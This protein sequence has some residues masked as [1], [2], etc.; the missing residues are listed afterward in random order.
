M[1][2]GSDSYQR[3]VGGADIVE[4][5]RPVPDQASAEREGHFG[6]VGRLACERVPHAAVGEFAHAV[7]VQRPYRARILELDQAAERVTGE[8]AEQTA[9]RSAPYFLGNGCRPAC[10]RVALCVPVEGVQRGSDVL[11][12]FQ[13]VGSGN[14]HESFGQSVQRLAHRPGNCG[15]GVGVASERHRV[16]RRVLEACRFERADERCR[17]RALARHIEAM[18]WADRLQT[19]PQVVA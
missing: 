8:L 11:G 15:Q 6:V 13:V 7:G 9:L 18:G 10:R 12:M 5:K 16:S 19:L 14:P 4:R 1:T 3:T 17:H 2:K